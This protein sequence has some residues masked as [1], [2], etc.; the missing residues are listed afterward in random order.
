MKLHSYV[1]A[2]DDGFAPNPFHGSCTL[3]T[4]KPKIRR[5]SV[6]GDWI[7]G[8]GSKRK[9]RDQSLVYA[10]RITE[11]M[12]YND[13]WNDMRF[14][15][16]RPSLFQS[17]RKSRGDNI[18]HTET[19]TG[20]WIQE[21]SCHSNKDGTP[22]AKH[23]AVDT[24]CDNVLISEDFIY[25]GGGPKLD[26]PL[27]NDINVCHTGIGHTSNFDEETIKAFL[28]WVRD[29]GQWGYCHDPLNWK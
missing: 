29:L 8:T 20:K 21:D 14:E 1:V 2:I 23:I 12:T 26:V 4:C 17:V 11:T 24:S 27:F 28:D 19:V 25:Y 15:N 9:G 7:L 13:Y 18:Y 16:K 22:N 5:Y 3:A 6:V 10:M